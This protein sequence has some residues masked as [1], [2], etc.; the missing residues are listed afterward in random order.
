VIPGFTLSGHIVEGTPAG[1][2]PLSGGHVDYVVEEGDGGIAPIAGHVAADL[3][4]R[5]AIANIPA[6]RRVRVTGFTGPTP[7]WMSQ[8]SPTSAIINT[9]TEMDIEL[10]SSGFAGSGPAPR[11]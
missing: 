2:G 5:Y 1:P 9:D 10:V 6:G 11:R 8:R 4:G 7:I 3:Y